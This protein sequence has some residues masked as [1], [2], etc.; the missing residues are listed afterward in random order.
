MK[1]AKLKGKS[2]TTPWVSKQPNRT[3]TK[4]WWNHSKETNS[5]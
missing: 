5:I 1:A 2:L 3:S 4:Q